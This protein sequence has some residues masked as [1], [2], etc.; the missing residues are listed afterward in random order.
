MEAAM[1]PKTE[2]TA[3]EGSEAEGMPRLTQISSGLERRYPVRGWCSW[4]EVFE[5]S[6][7]EKGKKKKKAYR[8]SKNAGVGLPL[9]GPLS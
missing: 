7:F 4:R 6:G 3:A 1:W 8:A 2:S 9:R 5:M